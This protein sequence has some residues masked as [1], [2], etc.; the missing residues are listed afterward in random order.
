MRR[1]LTTMMLAFL[2]SACSDTKERIYPTKTFSFERDG[3]TYV[4]EA[5]YDQVGFVWVTHTWS[6]GRALTAKDK[7]LVMELVT[8]KVGPQ[9]CDGRQLAVTGGTALNPLAGDDV[10]FLERAGEWRLAGSCA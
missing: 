1:S 8:Q 4:V 2:L 7:A 3:V 9:I 10:L 5:D 6:A